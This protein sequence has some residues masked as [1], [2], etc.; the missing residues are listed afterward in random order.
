MRKALPLVAILA[1]SMS[2]VHS[3]AAETAP[4]LIEGIVKSLAGEQIRYSYHFDHNALKDAVRIGGALIALTESG[5]L[6]R[7]DEGTFSLTAQRI[8]PGKGVAISLSN[9]RNIFIGTKEGQVFEVDPATLALKR[10]LKIRGEI[11]W[12]TVKTEGRGPKIIAAVNNIDNSDWLSARPGEPLDEFFE[13]GVKFRNRH[14]P[15]FFILIHTAKWEKKIPVSEGGINAFMLDASD[16]LWLAEDKGEWGGDC[17]RVDLDTGT[18]KHYKDWE[19]ILGFLHCRDGRLFAYGGIVHF[20]LLSGFIARIDKD[21]LDK[22]CH[23]PDPT[24]Q[25]DLGK[26]RLKTDSISHPP[27]NMPEG[28]VDRILEDTGDSG[29]WVLSSHLIYHCDRNFAQWKKIADIGGWFQAGRRAS[30]GNTPT[31]NQLIE[32]KS[33]PPEFIAVMG[34]DGLTRISSGKVQNVQIADQIESPVVEIWPTSIGTVFLADRYKFEG[35][36]R[37][38]SSGWKKISFSPDRNPLTKLEGSYNAHWMETEPIA[39]YDNGLISYY[40]SNISPG[41]RG[42]I[43][44]KADGTKEEL[45]N[46]EEYSADKFLGAYSGRI[47]GIKSINANEELK[48]WDGKSWRPG[49]ENNYEENMNW[50][51]VLS[52]RKY[53]PLTRAAK[54]EI[55]LDA[56]F[57]NLLQ[58]QQSRTAYKL[59]PLNANKKKAPIGIY[60]AVVDK[61]GWLLAATVTGPVRY[62]P[63][64]DQIKKISA[65]NTIEE[66]ITLCRDKRGRLW[67]AGDYLYVSS[68]EGKTWTSVGLPML[69]RTQTKRIRMDPN[70]ANGLILAMYD[71]GLVFL[72]W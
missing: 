22:V 55:F 1:I 47:I 62:N 9:E 34:M 29:F 23:F 15:P 18:I 32:S 48:L 60:D 14:K 52:A 63:E 19:N 37:L 25:H 8:V 30:M 69:S 39:D 57:G 49:G 59:Q 2:I 11:I 16:R 44:I 7:F 28:P 27:E 36:W 45:G 4:Y 68:D 70:N 31:V 10:L 3:G 24:I 42:L 50:M 5:N 20:S 35:G 65:P 13:R 46:W 67:I 41:E 61:P 71:R 17:W 56:Q 12:L 6:L 43:K 66:F 21:R 33:N 38:S 64:L 58:L 53:I 72:N 40:E 26:T 54:F 51:P